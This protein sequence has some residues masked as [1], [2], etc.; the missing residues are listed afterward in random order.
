MSFKSPKKQP[1][2]VSKKRSGDTVSEAVGNYEKHPFFIKK[3][4]IA[5]AHLSKVGLPKQLTSKVHLVCAD[6]LCPQNYK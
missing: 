6:N 3:A 4:A 5:K 2:K 1:K